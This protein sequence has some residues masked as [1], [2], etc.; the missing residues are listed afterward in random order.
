ME[1]QAKGALGAT[2]KLW[3]ELNRLQQAALTEAGNGPDADVASAPWVELKA[4]AAKANKAVQAMQRLG[5]DEAVR[6]DVRHGI[7]R[8]AVRDELIDREANAARV[9]DRQ[10]TLAEAQRDGATVLER[11]LTS[12]RGV[13]AAIG[14]LCPHQV[15][16]APGVALLANGR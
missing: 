15:H 5:R 3:H 6:A 8:E 7:L 12:A 4:L 13:E 14:S 11:S 2:K 9:L 10:R 1:D 16:V